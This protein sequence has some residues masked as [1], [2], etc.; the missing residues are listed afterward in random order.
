MNLFYWA[1]EYSCFVKTFIL[2]TA[3]VISAGCFVFKPFTA[4]GCIMKVTFLKK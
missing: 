1:S 3:C 4:F 2:L